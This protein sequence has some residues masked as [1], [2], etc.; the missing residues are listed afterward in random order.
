MTIMDN[1]VWLIK[2][3]D[4]EATELIVEIIRNKKLLQ[5]LQID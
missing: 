4:P 3:R 5:K 1:E 2:L